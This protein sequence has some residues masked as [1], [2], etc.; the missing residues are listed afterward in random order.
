M[1]GMLGENVM[2]G[3]VRQMAWEEA[4]R[5]EDV[6]KLDVRNKAMFDVGVEEGGEE[7]RIRS[8]GLR[9]FRW[10]RCEAVW[11]R[12]RRRRKWR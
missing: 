12:F 4:L 3:L 9:I 6:F 5:R 7:R 1:A 2:K 11:R 10:R 8:L